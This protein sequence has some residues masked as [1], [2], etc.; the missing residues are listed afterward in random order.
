MS[1]LVPPA[2]ADSHPNSGVFVSHPRYMVLNTVSTSGPD[3][4]STGPG[5]N[6]S[7]SGPQPGAWA[8]ALDTK[9]A[10]VGEGPADEARWQRFSRSVFRVLLGL[11]TLGASHTLGVWPTADGNNLFSGRGARFDHLRRVPVSRASPSR[12]SRGVTPAV[13]TTGLRAGRRGRRCAAPRR[14]RSRRTSSL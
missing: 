13:R 1:F 8:D 2:L 9:V 10:A 11:G 12:R 7:S 4:T 6:I 5:G 3:P 14:T